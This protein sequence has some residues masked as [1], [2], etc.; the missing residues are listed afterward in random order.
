LWKIRFNIAYRPENR[1]VKTTLAISAH[2]SKDTAFPF[3]LL[4]L[5]STTP[6]R[7]FS[8]NAD[9]RVKARRVEQKCCFPC[10]PNSCFGRKA[11]VRLARLP[12]D[13]A[14]RVGSYEKR[15]GPPM[16]SFGDA[17]IGLCLAR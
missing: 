7:R 3:F 4:D 9:G 14:I 1:P 11:A 2:S 17:R 5:L 8:I 15:I 10:K 12:H 16:Q 13:L 6:G